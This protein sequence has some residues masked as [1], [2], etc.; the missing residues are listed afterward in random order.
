MG[1]FT[2][3]F[4]S[5]KE[6]AP[7]FVTEIDPENCIGCGRCFKAC[8][9]NV[10]SLVSA[11]G[12]GNVDVDEDEDDDEYDKKIMVISHKENCIGCEACSKMCPKKCITNEPAQI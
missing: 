1:N 10:L 3:T 7:Q 9:Q 8:S 5:G 4:P 2:V 11:D 12:N 6:W